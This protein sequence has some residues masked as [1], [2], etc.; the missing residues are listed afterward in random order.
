MNLYEAGLEVTGEVAE[1]VLGR[2]RLSLPQAV[3]KRVS[4]LAAY[5]GGTVIAGIRPESLAD[6]GSGGPGGRRRSRGPASPL[7]SSWSRCS[8]ASSWSTSTWTRGGS[9]RKPSSAGS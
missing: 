7:T 9:G 5:H 2:Q 1:L 3:L 6:P 4:G 8:A